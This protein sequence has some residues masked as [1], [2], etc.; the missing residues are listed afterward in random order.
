MLYIRVSLMTPKADEAPAVA[1]IMDELLGF[2][3]TQPG[4]LSGY[5]LRSADAN[6]QIGR[7]TVWRAGEDA[8]ATAQ[9]QHVLAQRSELTPLIEEHSHTE[10]SFDAAEASESLAAMVG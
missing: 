3:A 4:F 8:D 7:V 5:K 1:R 6:Q 9:H 2:Y 10:W